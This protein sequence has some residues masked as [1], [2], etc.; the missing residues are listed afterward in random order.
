MRPAESPL[1]LF[2]DTTGLVRRTDPGTAR[3]AAQAQR[4]GAEHA[5]LAMLAD[6]ADATRDEIAGALPGWHP[7]TLSTALSRLLRSG[8]VVRTGAARPGARGLPQEVVQLADQEE[9]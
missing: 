4:G 9:T 8:K 6:V 7:P 3:G 2:G 5:I 1:E